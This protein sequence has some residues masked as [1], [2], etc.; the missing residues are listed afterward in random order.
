MGIAAA[1]LPVGVDFL[2]VGHDLWRQ[3]NELVGGEAIDGGSGLGG[4]GRWGEG[5]GDG[6]VQGGGD[7]GGLRPRW[8]R[9]IGEN[10]RGENRGRCIIRGRQSQW[11]FAS[12]RLTVRYCL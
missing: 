4:A 7:G 9:I 3:D 11:E 8:G 1:S 2:N 6:R 10:D 5:G 12:Y